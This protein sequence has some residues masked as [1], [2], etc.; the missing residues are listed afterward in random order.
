MAIYYAGQHL[1]KHTGG[2]KIPTL[3][4]HAKEDKLTL[5]SGSEMFAKN[6]PENVTLRI[7]EDVY[8]EMHN[9]VKRDELFDYTWSWM[10]KKLNLA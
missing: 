9:D 6:N 2:V 5:A 8:H 3:V 4:M 10:S 1:Y 7:W